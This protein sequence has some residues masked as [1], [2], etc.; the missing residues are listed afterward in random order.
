[1]GRYNANLQAGGRSA[2]GNLLAIDRTDFPA[3]AFFRRDFAVE[4]LIALMNRLAFDP[5]ALL[6]DQG[7]WERFHLNTGD[8]VQLRI[9]LEQLQTLDFKVA[10]VVDYFPTQYPEDGPFFIANLDY[11]FESTGGLQPYDVWLRTAQ[12]AD[13]Q[14]IVLGVNNLGVAVIRAQDARRLLAQTFQA[15]NRQGMLGLLSVGFLA[16]LLL[17]VVGFLLYALFSFR[18]RFIQLGVL[19]AIGLSRTQM[20]AYLALEQFF[21][22]L[23]GL[24]VGTGIAVLTADL[25]IPHLTGT[26]G[27]HPGVPPSVVEIAWEDILRVYAVFGGMLL[28]GMLA[29][30]VS[31]RRMRIFQAIKMGEN[32]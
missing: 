20:A 9:R 13:P 3:V 5:A 27:L 28:V 16:A 18:E 6:V 10:G 32:A 19:R 26:F 11:L 24:A 1:V 7:T 4:P 21:L 12:D 25:F 31:L 8:T 15:P 2:G 29:T 22:I 23:T 30:L 17:T 14:A